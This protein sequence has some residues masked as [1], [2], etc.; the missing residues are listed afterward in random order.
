MI[1]IH[2][3]LVEERGGGNCTCVIYNDGIP[4]QKGRDINDITNTGAFAP[5]Y[6][7]GYS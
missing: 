4:F 3:G 6:Q 1:D 7:I 5:D 2:L